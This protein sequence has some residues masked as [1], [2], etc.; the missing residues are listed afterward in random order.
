MSSLQGLLRQRKRLPEA[1]DK[2]LLSL[3]GALYRKALPPPYHHAHPEVSTKHPPF[4]EPPHCSQLEE[5]GE[6]RLPTPPSCP[7]FSSPLSPISLSHL[8]NIRF[9]KRRAAQ[10]PLHHGPGHLQDALPQEL[11]RR[12]RGIEGNGAEL[13]TTPQ[14]PTS[15]IHTLLQ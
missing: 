7:Q 12:G 15:F 4:S 1:R 14:G 13:Q 5:D 11:E 10:G 6:H 9:L 3:S 2:V 8:L